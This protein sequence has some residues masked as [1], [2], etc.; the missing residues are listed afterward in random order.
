MGR[1]GKVLTKKEKEKYRKELD[2][3]KK[4]SIALSIHSVFVG[5]ISV[6][7]QD[8]RCIAQIVVSKNIIMI[9]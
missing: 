2:I 8:K 6:L 7:F 1:N 3:E 5:L 4:L 9:E